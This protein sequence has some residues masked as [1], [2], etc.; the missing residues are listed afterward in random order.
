[1]TTLLVS[2]LLLLGSVRELP[3]SRSEQLASTL[4]IVA[5]GAVLYASAA[6]SALGGSMFYA[7]G[8]GSGPL[9]VLTTGLLAASTVLLWR[10]VR[11]II[12][13]ELLAYTAQI[14]PSAN[15]FDYVIDPVLWIIAFVALPMQRSGRRARAGG[16]VSRISGAGV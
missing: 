10:Y 1:M 11:I 14:L 9:V 15:W 16:D 12:V 5:I 13:A 3:L 7:L 2:V 6:R 4:L 8:F